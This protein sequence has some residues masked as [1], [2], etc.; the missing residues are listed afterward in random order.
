MPGMQRDAG[1][2]PFRIVAPG[3]AGQTCLAAVDA[4]R[5]IGTTRTSQTDPNT[6]SHLAI[7][8]WNHSRVGVASVDLSARMRVRRMG[9]GD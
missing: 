1:R 9:D 5:W 3:G 2:E 4:A 8:P 7:D 6:A